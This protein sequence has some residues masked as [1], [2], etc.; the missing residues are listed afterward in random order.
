MSSGM[1]LILLIIAALILYLPT[2]LWLGEAWWSDP[3][4]SHGPLVA[5]VSAYLIWSRRRYFGEIHLPNDWGWLLLVPALA[6]HLWAVWW[7]AYYISALTMP[8]LLLAGLIILYGWRAS[9]HFLFPLAF[10]VLM[11]PLPLVE[12]FGPVLEGWSAISA[13]AAARFFGV[14]ATNDG[15]QVF[16]PNSAFTVGI[17]CGGLRSAISIITLTTLFTYIVRGS[18]A[19]RLA[20]FSAAIPIALAA[21]TLRLSLLFA[22]AQHWGEQV[23]MDYFHSWSSPVLFFSAFA[24]IVALASLFRCSQVRWEAILPA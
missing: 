8:V 21:N 16:L 4:Y 1:R 5:I 14:A 23:G 17:P 13:T 9:K 20:I 7:S 2:W 22:I 10:L 6:I 15:A 12:R 11:V 18:L 19:A 24:L 3:Y